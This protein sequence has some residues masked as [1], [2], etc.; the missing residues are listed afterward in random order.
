MLKNPKAIPGLFSYHRNLTAGTSRI[1][2]ICP[3]RSLK[4]GEIDCMNK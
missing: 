2:V 3:F 4:V 1:T